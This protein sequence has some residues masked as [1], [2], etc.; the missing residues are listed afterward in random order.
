M[1]SLRVFKQN[2]NSMDLAAADYTPT[3][4]ST[5]GTELLFDY[6]VCRGTEFDVIGS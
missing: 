3:L 1:S 2:T 6:N 5:W 4:D